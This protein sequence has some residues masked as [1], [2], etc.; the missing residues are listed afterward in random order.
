MAASL[1]ERAPELGVLQ[2]AVAEAAA[3]RGSVVLVLGEAGIGK[4]SLLRA[5]LKGVGSSVAVL[6]G[7]CD[8]LL[9]PRALGPLWDAARGR[10]GPLADALASANPGAV[11]SAVT[12][13]LSDGRHPTVL[14]VED[15]HWADS[16]TLDV[17]RYV[18]RRDRWAARRPAAHLPRRRARP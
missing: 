13:E 9:T 10:R 5:F 1:L 17:V 16:A 3:G 18:G 2:A 15:V 7:S 14:V 8:D 4:T 11:F 6:A 12:D